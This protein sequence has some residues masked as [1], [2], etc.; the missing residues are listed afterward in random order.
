MKRL[1]FLTAAA[2]LTSAALYG[3]QSIPLKFNTIE[4]KDFL[5]HPQADDRGYPRLSYEISFTY[6]SEYGDKEVLSALQRAFIER[7][8][9]KKYASLTPEKAVKTRIDDWKTDYLEET[10]EDPYTYEY[11]ATDTILFMNDA[12][13]QMR[14][15]DYSAEG[16][17]HGA[18]GYSAHLFNL[19]TGKEYG[20]N[21]I[22]KPESKDNIIQTLT[23][24]L[25]KY[26]KKEGVNTSSFEK[27]DVWTEDTGFA[28]T[29]QGIA[30]YYTQYALGMYPS[31]PENITIPFKT[32]LPF[33]RENTPVWELAKGAGTN[34]AAPQNNMD[35]LAK[36]IA[37]QISEIN[38]LLLKPTAQKENFISY[39][40]KGEE[41]SGVLQIYRYVSLSAPTDV[42][43]AAF[44]NREAPIECWIN[45]YKIDRKTGNVT[46]TKLPFDLPRPSIFDDDA[47]GEN[48]GY[49]RQEYDISDNGDVLVTA[50]PGMSWICRFII[51]WNEKSGFTLLPQVGYD[52]MAD[53]IEDEIIDDAEMEKYVQ[54]VVRPDFQ[55]VNNIKN[56]FLV[57]SKESRDISAKG[58]ALITYYYSK[59]G[60][61][62]VVAK[63]NGEAGERVIEYYL[64]HGR[65]SFI[66]DVTTQAPNPKTERRWYF[67]ND[68]CFRVIG[69]N[70]KKLTP[71]QINKESNQN[72]AA[73]SIFWKIIG[74]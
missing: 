20:R 73:N 26:W 51:R 47:F 42:A 10:K 7:V 53:E 15:Y 66:Y 69:E 6:P 1:F 24:E 30:F 62:K 44:T 52:Y 2:I 14:E 68:R 58:R 36:K 3:Q 25:L 57:E 65:L 59:S 33:L 61:E 55:R 23:A 46:E 12:L 74:I 64:L 21:D 71:A 60:L 38:G 22:F 72:D 8:L 67:K 5:K 17:A 13:L 32:I 43:L 19:K 56:W 70:G 40:I 29:P 41:I 34:A 27:K 48:G 39:D 50:A 11:I 28:V 63:I 49:W 37:A 31:V 9:G 35:S 16:G 4:I 18:G 54:N 45:F